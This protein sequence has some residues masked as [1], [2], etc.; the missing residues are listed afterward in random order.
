MSQE[1]FIEILLERS[2]LE[3][4]KHPK[5]RG[6]HVLSIDSLRDGKAWCS[7]GG[8]VFRGPTCYQ[9]IFS[10]HEK[11]RKAVTNNGN[12]DANCV[13]RKNLDAR[14]LTADVLEIL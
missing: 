3:N 2:R 11:H 10:Q 7:C 14:D 5:Y 1:T 12:S 4:P 9:Q 8:W 6:K 13:T